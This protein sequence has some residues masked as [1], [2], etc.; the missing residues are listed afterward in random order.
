MD[1]K[2]KATA[3]AVF[4]TYVAT[5]HERD[6]TFRRI[7]A[8]R[9]GPAL[10]GTRASLG[11][12]GA[13]LLEPV[14]PGP[15]DDE[16]PIWAWDRDDDDPYLKGSWLPDGLGT[17]A[18]GILRRRHPTLTWTLEEDRR[19]IY[20]GKP[21]LA[22]LGPVEW[23]PYAAMLGYLRLAREATPPD[24]D[25]LLT[26]FDTWSALAE[27][28]AGGRVAGAAEDIDGDEE[29]TV[30]A[31]AGD[32]DWDA[33]LWIPESAETDLG[34]AAYDA[35]YDRFAAIPGVERLAWED[36]ERFLLRLRRGTRIDDVAE[37][38]RRAFRDAVDTSRGG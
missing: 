14:P 31:I 29:V 2:A 19:S 6:A 10:D 34:R 12:L 22:G 36:R 30:E 33:E 38:A 26:A 8:S 13:W 35:L 5:E 16:K 32:Q 1:A 27:K 17:Y 37:A 3:R 4:E 18:L 20:E 11:P 15:E 25:W 28:A 24:P 9:G 7:V 23:L 21:L